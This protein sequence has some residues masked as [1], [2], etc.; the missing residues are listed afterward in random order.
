MRS[1][2]KALM[3]L[4]T[5]AITNPDMAFA[6]WVLNGKNVVND[7]HAE[8]LITTQVKPRVQEDHDKQE[9]SVKRTSEVPLDADDSTL[10]ISEFIKALTGEREQLD[11]IEVLS[12]EGTLLG[13]SG[14]T[15]VKD[16]LLPHLPNLKVLNLYH[17]GLKSEEAMDLISSILNDFSNIQFVDV[18][19]NNL[20]DD[21][22][23]YVGLREDELKQILQSKLVI[24][25][26]SLLEATLPEGEPDL[27]RWHQTHQTYYGLVR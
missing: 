25:F 20:E 16:E 26:K 22:T 15:K 21:F 23:R 4:C 13:T 24:A 14:L 27:S 9:I 2:T 19:A 5:L 3:I 18:V 17:S 11:S 7:E 1:T 8:Y 10:S 12:F 6:G